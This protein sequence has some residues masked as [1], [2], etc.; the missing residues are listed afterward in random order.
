[1]G[2]EE[3][4]EETRGWLAAVIVDEDHFEAVVLLHEELLDCAQGGR[5]DLGA[6][7]NRDDKRCQ[8]HG[9]RERVSHVAPAAIDGRC[10]TQLARLPHRWIERRWT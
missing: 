5:E 2:L 7:V 1:M 9:G 10:A 8:R 3:V 4:P 6:V